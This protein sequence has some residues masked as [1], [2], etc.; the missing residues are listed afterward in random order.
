[1]SIS[2]LPSS[3]HPDQDSE[4]RGHM[5]LSV[6]DVRWLR[7]ARVKYGPDVRVLDISAGGIF[8]ETE[9]QLRPDAHIV[10]ELSGPINSIL[11][12]SKVLRCRV[13][14][15]AEVMRYRG[16][17]AFERPLDIPDL[18]TQ[19][20]GTA[21]L[22]PA[23]APKADAST[24]WQRVVARF[25]DGHVVRGY[26][27]DFHP[28][29]PHLHLSAEPHSSDI[30]FLPLSQ[31]DALFFVRDVAGDPLRDE[32]QESFSTAQGRIVATFHD[33]ETLVDPTLGYC[34]GHTGLFVHRADPHSNN[35]RIFSAPG[36]TQ[37]VRFL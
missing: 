4:R 28:S 9:G 37:Q 24:S 3:V 22:P 23:A 6:A 17:C 5:R 25:R 16:A 2:T 36:P 26:T 20:M 34:G 13:A 18:V 27:A 10:F 1:M 33:S 15:V 30:L 31:L 35:L 19:A 32:R 7:S 8:V 12:P 21:A 29:N 14:S 11:V